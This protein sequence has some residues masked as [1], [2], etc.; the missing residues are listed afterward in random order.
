MAKNSG[1]AAWFYRQSFLIQLLLLFIP[2]VNWVVEV[3][4]RWSAFFRNGGLITLICAI[5]AIPAGMVF[6]WV[7]LIWLLLFRHFLFAKA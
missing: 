6:G 4:V 2:G 1:F 7:D 3:G 5:I